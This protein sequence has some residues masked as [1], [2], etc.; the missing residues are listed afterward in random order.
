MR[1]DVFNNIVITIKLIVWSYW[2]INHVATIA[3]ST[4]IWFDLSRK[5]LNIDKWIN[6]ENKETWLKMLWMQCRC[7]AQGNIYNW[8]R[9]WPWCPS[10]WEKICATCVCHHR[11]LKPELFKTCIVVRGDKLDCDIDTGAPSTNLAEFKVLLNSIISDRKQD[12]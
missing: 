5:R 4:I 6:G 3:N 11:Q 2:I 8:F 9:I 7:L 1:H 10:Q 12:F